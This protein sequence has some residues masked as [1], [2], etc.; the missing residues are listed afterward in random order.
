[1]CLS[2]SQCDCCIRPPVH[3]NNV[4]LPRQDVKYLGLHLDSRLTWCKHISAKRKQPEVTLTRNSPRATRLIYKANLKPVWT[5]GTHLWGTA[6]NL[7]F[8]QD[9]R[10]T[11]LRAEYMAQPDN[12]RLRRHLP[13]DL[14]SRIYVCFI[15]SYSVRFSLSLSHKP[16]P[17]QYLSVTEE[18]Y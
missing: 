3:I 2:K 11:L 16:Q 4:Q 1:L 8:V 13:N 6:S 18:R 12:R 15:Y 17:V 14:P 9:C 5:Y 7:K 10:R